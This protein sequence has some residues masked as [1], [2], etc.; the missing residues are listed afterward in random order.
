MRTPAARAR[1][2]LL[3]VL[4][5]GLLLRLWLAYVAFPGQGFAGD[6]R[7][8]ARWAQSLA[9]NGP[10]VFYASDPTANYP[11]AYMYVLWLL[12]RLASGDTLVLLLKLPAI[13]ADVGVAALLARLA[14]RWMGPPAGVVAAALY[15]FIPVTWYDSALWGQVD[16]VP[17][18]VMMAALVLLVEGWSEPAAVLA[19][20]AVMT[21]PQAL[22]CLVV[23]VPVLV[24]RHLL[25]VGSGPV[26]VRSGPL[27]V[28]GPVRL[29]TSALAAGAVAVA[30]LVP[31]DVERFAP[32][33]LAAVPVV[34]DV[35]GLV[36]LVRS[37]ADQFSVLSAN[38][39]NAWALVG[40]Q[41]LVQTI[42]S[43]SAAWTPDSLPVLGDIS[44]ATLGT[45]LLV[46]VALL[47]AG[48]LLTRDG[49]LPI[50]LGFTVI[51]FAFY[52][53]PTRVHERY[54]FPAFAS[55]AVLG[56][57]VLARAIAF[58]AAGLLNT[59]NLHAVLAAPSGGGFGGGRGGIGLRGGLGGGPPG[60]APRGPGG[61]GGGF[62]PTAGIAI[63]DV[64]LP[65]ADLARS[66]AVAAAVA[67]GQ[68]AVL[69]VLLVAWL[70]LLLAG[71][72]RPITEPS[73]SPA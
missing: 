61:P 47:V 12:G 25:A 11:P 21:K 8:F 40:P 35:A 57:G 70:A 51:A 56:A 27:A 4:G 65:L 69:V 50:A 10:G 60:F 45:V 49:V 59:I 28:Q 64:H 32:A 19:A 6:V 29:V 24:R 43:G 15:L 34:A 33:S 14:G 67:L 13:L 66:P 73:R 18:L 53:V 41:P 9:A 20:V 58:A 52:A 1:V 38:A 68:T 72:R 2:L 17:A 31:F 55:G 16:A 46:A 30:L 23:V 48:G 5:G 39:Y 3:A 71:R 7:L 62:G 22:V 37:A 42:A 54:L 36:G 44:A 26:P 63:S